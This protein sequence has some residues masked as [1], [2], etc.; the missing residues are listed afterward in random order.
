MVFVA[1]AS[2]AEI[3]GREPAGGLY[4]DAVTGAPIDFGWKVEIGEKESY[5]TSSPKDRLTHPL[6]REKGELRTAS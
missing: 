3:Y 2:G 4:T 1:R 5:M 6:I